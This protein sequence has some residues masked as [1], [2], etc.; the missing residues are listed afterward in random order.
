MKKKNEYCPESIA[1]IVKRNISTK[2]T[3]W[4]RSVGKILLEIQKKN[5][6][7][8]KTAN[9]IPISEYKEGICNKLWKFN[10]E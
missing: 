1:I 9:H 10:T 8:K 7:N 6:L 5:I 2:N 3:K 4:I